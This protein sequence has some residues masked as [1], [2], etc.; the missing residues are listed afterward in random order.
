MAIASNDGIGS[1]NNPSRF[2]SAE[3]AGLATVK[4]L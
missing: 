3:R 2:I 1:A 4:E